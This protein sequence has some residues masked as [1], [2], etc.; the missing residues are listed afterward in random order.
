[1]FAQLMEKLDHNSAKN[2]STAK[3]LSDRID[4]YAAHCA[5]QSAALK[6]GL[7]AK[8]DALQDALNKQ[9]DSHKHTLESQVCQLEQ[10]MTSITADLSEKV[11]SNYQGLLDLT[12]R[13]NA[14]Q[15]GNDL[16][17]EELA[18][19]I[20]SLVKEVLKQNHPGVSSNQVERLQKRVSALESHPNSSSLT[21]SGRP[22]EIPAPPY[23][24]KVDPVA[25]FCHFD[26]LSVRNGWDLEEQGLRLTSQLR[27]AAQ[28][29][30]GSLPAERQLHYASV[31]DA[32][33]RR[34][35]IAGRADVG[36]ASLAGRVQRKGES[37]A[38]LATD[39][40]RLTLQAY[41]SMAVESR[42]ELEVDHF[43]GAIGDA[44]LQ[45]RVRWQKPSNLA[46]AEHM[47]VEGE[48][49]MRATRG[50][51]V[52]SM[53]AETPPEVSG[54][55][56]IKSLL[57]QLQQ[58]QQRL[59]SDV[60]SLT[61]ASPALTPVSQ[62]NPIFRPSG[63]D[64]RGPPGRFLTCTNCQQVGHAAHFCREPPRNFPY[65]INGSVAHGPAP[66]SRFPFRGNA[67]L[68]RPPT[69]GRGQHWRRGT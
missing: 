65:A 61:R 20:P 57:Q 16:V 37:L 60:H 9:L 49:A 17:H 28:T 47:A 32:L 31:K 8:I 69:P 38:E 33:L 6:T 59:C 15:Q 19:K 24:G 29:V 54:P 41:P 35:T 50:R 10:S 12:K 23:D 42:R 36:R 4:S 62:S 30:L 18:R 67:E 3:V 64:T 66:P 63:P 43:V 7:D 13:V 48:S 26:A 25:Y 51:Y 11:S 39:I 46:E 44:E 5:T 40:E 27:G 56:E 52:R 21:M 58:Q 22:K 1:M 55:N 2:D 68:S 45:L 34:F 14:A 53:D